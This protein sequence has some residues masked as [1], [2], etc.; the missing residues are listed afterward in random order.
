MN[1]VIV[2]ISGGM[3]STVLLHWACTKFDVVHALSFDYT[4]ASNSSTTLP[5]FT[6][7]AGRP[8]GA[9]KAFSGSIPI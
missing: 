5:S 7:A 1:R 4:Q 2:P 6:M 3:D 8:P 9:I